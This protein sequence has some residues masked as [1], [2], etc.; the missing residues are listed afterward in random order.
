MMYVKKIKKKILATEQAKT[1][2]NMSP[3]QKMRKMFEKAY[4]KLNAEEKKSLKN[5]IVSLGDMPSTEKLVKLTTWLRER[6]K[7]N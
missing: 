5:Y 3:V 1:K 4:E 7:I 6:G 2:C